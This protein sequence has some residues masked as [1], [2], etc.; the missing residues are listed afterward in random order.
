M[1]VGFTTAAAITIAS[2]QL[3]GLLG[4]KGKSNE[5]LESWISVSEHIQ[6]TRYQDLCLGLLTIF[7]LASLKVMKK[8]SW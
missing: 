2:S 6:E 7:V 4:I 5:F 8:A 3:K 1:T